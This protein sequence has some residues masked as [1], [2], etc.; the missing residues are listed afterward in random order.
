MRLIDADKL[1]LHL[2]NYALQEAPSDTEC[3]GERRISNLTPYFSPMK[4]PRRS[5]RN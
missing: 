3:A 1:V 5:W 4:K 2:N